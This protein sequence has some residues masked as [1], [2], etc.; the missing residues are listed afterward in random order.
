MSEIANLVIL[1]TGQGGFQLAMSLREEGFAGR[2][3]MVGDEASLPYQRPPLSKAFL[4]GAVDEEGV[5]LR[6]AAFFAENRIDV[7]VSTRAVRIDAEQRRLLLENGESLAYDHLA[8]ATGARN[9][10]LPVIG[11]DLEGVMRLRD[12]AEAVYIRDVLP[13]V[14]R[15]VVIGAGFI[16]LEFAAS[17]RAKGIEVTVI[18]AGPRPM[19]RA[20]SQTMSDFFTAQHTAKGITLRFQDGVSRIVGEAGRVTGVETTSGE[21]IG[22][23]LVL[24]GIGVLPN[25]EL[26]L[27]AGIAVQDGILVDEFMATSD[28]HISAYGDCARAPNRY[29]PAPLRL[30]SVQNT[31][32]QAR[33]LAQRLV[34]KPTPYIALPWFWSEQG[35]LKLQMVGLTTPHDEAVLR[36]DPASGA[37]SVFCFRDGRWLGAESVNRVPEHML[38]RRLLARQFSTGEAMLSP[39]QAADVG[40]DLKSLLT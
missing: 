29:S 20:I 9:R 18:E 17:A 35:S 19:A 36:G 32:D 10:L 23:D 25:V 24:I 14:R 16:G 5:Q 28:P 6:P 37:F 3:V 2:I 34:G 40:F 21:L 7:R 1:G 13:R 22:A 31:V 38:A 39:A 27:E 33:C 8:I 15:A 11:A 12:M 26:A 4:S 30:E